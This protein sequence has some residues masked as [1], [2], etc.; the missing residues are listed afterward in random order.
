MAATERTDAA[1]QADRLLAGAAEAVAGMRNFWLVTAGAGGAAQ[2]RPVERLRRDPYDEAW[3]IRF[4]TDGRS[5]KAA[6]IRRDGRVT[7]IFQRDADD[8]FVAVSGRA[9]L[10]EE[11]AERSRRWKRA[12]DGF[13]PTEAERAHAVFVEIEA[14]RL[15]LWIRGV[16]PEPF[17]LRPTMLERAA[18]GGWRLVEG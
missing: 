3:R 18:D 4:L 9:R 15:E 11:E 5:R 10:R 6:E 13:F 16:T 17:G 7:A 12:F 8:A 2:A 14:E 1:A